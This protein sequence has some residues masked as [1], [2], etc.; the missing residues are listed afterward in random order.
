MLEVGNGMTLPE[1][2]AHFSM[3]SMLAAPLLAGN[4][5]RTMSTETK[6]ILTN[7]EVIAVDQDPLGIQGW[8][9][10]DEGG[11]EI[12]FRPLA[13][14]DWAMCILNRTAGARAVRLDWRREHVRDDFSRRAADF[15]RVTYRIRDLWTGAELGTTATPL[16]ADVPGHDVLMVRLATPKGDAGR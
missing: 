4:D 7:R 1:D 10:L 3:W 13:G 11:L 6:A 5:L 15:D 9:Y 16:A 14:D 2:R 8:K 12:W